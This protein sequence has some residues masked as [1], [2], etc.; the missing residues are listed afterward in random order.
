MYEYTGAH[1]PTCLLNDVTNPLLPENREATAKAVRELGA[2]DAGVAW[3]GDCDRCF[4]FDEQGNFIEGYI[5]LV[6]WPRRSCRRI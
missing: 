1:I 2:D 3:D 5:W 4:M 6:F